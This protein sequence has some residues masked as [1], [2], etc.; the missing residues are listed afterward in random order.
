MAITASYDSISQDLTV[1]GDAGGN[2]IT[3]SRNLA[4]ALLVNNG[5]VPVAGGA[6]TVANTDLIEVLGDL[7]NDVV[8]ID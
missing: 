3:V 8:T 1:T 7:G 2:A 6:P 4:G 5:A